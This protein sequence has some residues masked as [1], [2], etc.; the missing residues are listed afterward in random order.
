M[1]R[2]DRMNWLAKE[3]GVKKAHLCRLLGKT[4]Y[5]LRDAEKANTDIKGDALEILAA[6]LGTTPEYL[7]GESD[8]K[9]PAGKRALSEED[10]KF[11]FFGGDA[12]I[13]TEEDMEDMRKVAAIIIER[14]K[15]GGT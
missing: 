11:A 2:Y 12:G 3:K 5:Y 10:I 9:E 6:A 7:T 14:R 15:R 13:M 4:Q 1:F 8:E